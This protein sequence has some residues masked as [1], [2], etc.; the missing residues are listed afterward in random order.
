MSSRLL[1]TIIIFPIWLTL[2]IVFRRHRQWLLY[3]LFGAF[4]LT[5]QLVFMAEYFGLDQILVNVA[6]FHV[7]LISKYIFRFPIELMAN[8]R[9]QLLL[10]DGSSSILQLGIECSAV[11][12]SS[13]LIALIGFYPLFN[14]RQKILRITFGLIVTYVINIIRLVIIVLMAYKFGSDY[15]YLAH[16]GVARIFF[17]VCELI[18]YWYLITKPTVKS[19]GSSILHHTNVGVEASIGHS[20]QLKHALIQVAVILIFVGLCV[21]SFKMTNDWQKALVPVAKDERPIVYQEETNLEILPP[22]GVPSSQEKP[23]VLGTQSDILDVKK[24]EGVIPEEYSLYEAEIGNS[25]T[26]NL[27]LEHNQPV[28]VKAYINNKLVSTSLLGASEGELSKEVLYQPLSLK[29]GDWLAIRIYNKGQATDNF[30]IEIT[31]KEN[32]E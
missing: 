13:I 12:E 8:G 32:R 26:I 19:V 18:L 15:I 30:V 23:K 4:G 21:G 17:F 29:K 9:F 10:P 5:L 1:A 20:L 6:S 11:L 14:F 7:S 28:L 31:N 25:E 2:I 24:I 16:A 22:E 27:A 3:Y